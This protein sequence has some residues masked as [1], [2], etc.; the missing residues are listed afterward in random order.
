MKVMFTLYIQLKLQGNKRVS[1]VYADMADMKYN[2][3]VD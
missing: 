2:L 1:I 3:A